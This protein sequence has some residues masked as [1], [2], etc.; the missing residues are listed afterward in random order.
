MALQVG[1]QQLKHKQNEAIKEFVSGR[2]IFPMGSSKSLCYAV[3]P[4]SVNIKSPLC[5]TLWQVIEADSAALLLAH[6][7][8]CLYV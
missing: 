3:P 5:T 6:S 2:D 7:H 8:G 4:A 1:Y